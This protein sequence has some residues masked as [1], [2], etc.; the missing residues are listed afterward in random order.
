[1]TLLHLHSLYSAQ[2]DANNTRFPGYIFFLGFV[3][4]SGFIYGYQI[5]EACCFHFQNPRQWAGDLVKLDRHGADRSPRTKEKETGDRFLFAP[6]E[7]KMVNNATT[8]PFQGQAG[9]Y[10]IS[11]KLTVFLLRQK[12]FCICSFR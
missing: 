7:R 4:P 8:T 10:R 5:F 1:M 3:T 11:R 2:R 6:I 9:D 12:D